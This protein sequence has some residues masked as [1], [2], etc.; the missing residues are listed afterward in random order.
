MSTK[1]Q[2]PIKAFAWSK[3]EA[4]ELIELRAWKA[5]ARPFLIAMEAQ[6]LKSLEDGWVDGMEDDEHD[7]HER[8]L[9]L[10]CNH[11]T[12]TELLKED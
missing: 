7:E 6:V 3:K 8:Y 11:D 4:K 2:G 1:D 10:E 5:K 9:T 12:L